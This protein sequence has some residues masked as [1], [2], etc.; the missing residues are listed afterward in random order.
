M[1]ALILNDLY[2]PKADR[3][4]PEVLSLFISQPIGPVNVL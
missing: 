1:P 2:P 3:D 4:G